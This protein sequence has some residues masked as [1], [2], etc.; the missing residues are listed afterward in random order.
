MFLCLLF[1]YLTLVTIVSYL[2]FSIANVVLAQTSPSDLGIAPEWYSLGRSAFIYIYCFALGHIMSHSL[3]GV[4]YLAWR[5]L[6]IEP[7]IIE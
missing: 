1:G 6:I 3:L 4:Y 2:A 7:K 5:T